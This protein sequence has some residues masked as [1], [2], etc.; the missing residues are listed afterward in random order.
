MGGKKKG[1]KKKGEG[2]DKYD[3]AQMTLIL[4][5]Q[6]QSLK[7]RLVL[8]GER[9]DKS[10]S[11]EESIRLRE[12][13]LCD[14]LEEQQKK[15]RMIVSEMTEQYKRMEKDLQ[16]KITKLQQKVNGQEDNIT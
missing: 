3:A 13:E 5:A 15:T 14:S 9:K 8:E 11:T 4:A 16:E 6:V 7:E 2:D 10:R 1:A 12:R